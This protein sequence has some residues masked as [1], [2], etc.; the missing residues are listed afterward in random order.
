MI[1][2]SSAENPMRMTKFA[3]HAKM[4]RSH[5]STYEG[6]EALAARP[7]SHIVAISLDGLLV[8][9]EAIAWPIRN[10]QVTVFQR[11]RLGDDRVGPVLPFEPV[12]RLGHAHQVSR[13]LRIEV[14]GHRNSRTPGDRR[15]PQP[16][17][18]SADAPQV[19]HHQIAHTS[20]KGLVERARPVE[21][22]AELHRGPQ[23]PCQL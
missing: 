10:N 7:G 18:H 14:R 9:R 3:A 6:M 1:D 5:T 23:L 16:A 22:L 11:E 15:G 13:R 8:P 2:G 4:S 20:L 17:G 19:R 21:I 12:S